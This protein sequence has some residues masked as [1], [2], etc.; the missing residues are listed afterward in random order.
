MSPDALA[1]IL[2]LAALEV[3]YFGEAGPVAAVRDVSFRIAR[4]ETLGLVGESGSGKSSIGLAIARQLPDNSRITKG[5][6][7]FD[8]VDLAQV[9]GRALR[10]ARGHRI[11]MVYQDPSGALNPS[12]RIGPQ[13]A[14]VYHGSGERDPRASRDRVISMLQR[15]RL[16]DAAYAYER[17]PHEFSGG[18]QQ[19][20][21]I[22][23]ALAMNP[24]LLILDE[25]TTGLDV[26]V[27]AEILDLFAELRRSLNAGILFISHNIAVIAKMC[28]RVGTL[29]DGQLVELGPTEEVLR[30]PSHPH[31]RAL[32]AAR[33]PFGATK[34]GTARSQQSGAGSDGLE[35]VGAVALIEV[36]EARKSYRE[37]GRRLQAVAGVDFQI[38][39][40]TVLGIVGES[41]SGK[42]TVAR[43]IAG[44]LV[45]DT[46]TVLL[47]GRDITKLAER[48]DRATRSAIQMVFQN[49]DSTLNPQHRIGRILRR[50]AIKLGGVRRR[51]ADQFVRQAIESV[52]LEPRHLNAFPEELSGGQRQR[53]AIARAFIGGPELVICDEPTSALDVSIQAS[54]LQLLTDLQSR[55]AASYI[56]IS[57]DLAVVRYISD[58]IAV[59]YLG[60]VVAI[61]PADRIFEPPHH[62]YA[63]A[64]LSAVL[65]LGRREQS[66][67]LRLGGFSP[68]LLDRPTGCPFHTRCPRKVG[69]ICESPPPWQETT[70]GDSY[71]CVIPPAVLEPLQRRDRLDSGRDA[72]KGDSMVQS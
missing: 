40:G 20:I 45:P 4:Q 21:V 41:G 66:Q 68:S 19:R 55:E 11:A 48:R 30:R 71:R 54:I 59:M 53:V 6:I 39:K 18:Q 69:A 7:R 44:L 62:P 23:M 12:L 8:G 43:L 5:S 32:L 25:P 72:L 57:H 13:I 51:D 10:K 2:D 38:T 33:I 1:P 3:V 29:H 31:T 22:A 36:R 52:R 14:E 61:G 50:A 67:G 63:E 16:P 46:G 58:R 27:E 28:D 49:P 47:H 56:F 64:L 9:E 15:V 17:Y 70:W 37:R 42:T 35:S 60:E 26:S 24:D 34:P 65:S